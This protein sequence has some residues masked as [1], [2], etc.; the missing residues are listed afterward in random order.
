MVH[1]LALLTLVAAAVITLREAR[2]PTA[3]HTAVTVFNGMFVRDMMGDV[4]KLVIYLVTGA[5][6]VYAKPYLM[7]RGL[8]KGEF[9]TLCLFAVLG[10]MFLVSAGNL[11]TVYL[12]LE[13]L[14]LRSTRWW[15]CSATTAWRR[16][17][18]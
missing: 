4:L 5:A 10:M 13:L 17:R 9:Y 18:R 2:W 15:R 1:F 14:A 8:F 16:K 3:R 6:F 7:D 12:G 11:V